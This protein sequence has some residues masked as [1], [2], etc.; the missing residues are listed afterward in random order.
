MKQKQ[1]ERILE[2]RIDI[3]G[4]AKDFIA[5][6]FTVPPK[7][8]IVTVG[9]SGR[10]LMLNPK[11]L[12]VLPDGWIRDEY[13]S[14]HWNKAFDV[15]PDNLEKHIPWQP[16][17]DHAASLSDKTHLVRLPSRFEILSWVDLGK[18]NPAII[19]AAKILNLKTD[20]WY[21]TEEDLTVAGD[22]VRARVVGIEDGYADGSIEGSI[23]Y[24]RPVRLSQ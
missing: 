5:A 6:G 1:V 23:R 8:R 15:A 9:V 19:E 11:R 17:R 16:G 24:V 7:N 18:Y 10:E 20:D 4:M 2:D 14:H 3:E 13:L 12:Y 22:P 21:W